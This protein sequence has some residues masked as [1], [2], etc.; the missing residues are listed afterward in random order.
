MV[1]CMLMI[2]A[3]QVYAVLDTV[4]YKDMAKIC[5]ILNFSFLMIFRRY[6]LLYFIKL[7]D[8]HT[9]DYKQINVL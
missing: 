5:P 7:N 8:E 9:K 2:L 1:C 4:A 6:S 3:E